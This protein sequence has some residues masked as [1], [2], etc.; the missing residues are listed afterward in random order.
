MKLTEDQIIERLAKHNI[1][2]LFTPR[3]CYRAGYED[4]MKQ[5]KPAGNII[6]SVLAWLKYYLSRQPRYKDYE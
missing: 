2:P 1:T 5:A 3:F 4:A 6:R